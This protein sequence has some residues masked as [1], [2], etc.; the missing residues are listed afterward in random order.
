[1]D[2]SGRRGREG[3]KRE[4][5]GR[6]ELMV[7]TDVI[8]VEA[9]CVAVS[10]ATEDELTGA[11]SESAAFAD[12]EATTAALGVCMRVKLQVRVNSYEKN[13]S[14]RTCPES[15]SLRLR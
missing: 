6:A 5:L 9:R 14:E 8:V 4:R 3:C 1:M 2:W 13:G 7:W 12:A 15:L 10:A 11:L